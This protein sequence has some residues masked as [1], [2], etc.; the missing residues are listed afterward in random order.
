MTSQ[1][2]DSGYGFLFPEDFTADQRATAFI[3]W[4]LLARV[5]TIKLAQVSAFHPG[6]GTPPTAGTVDVQ[7]LVNM[8]DG[9][10]PPNATKRGIVYGLPCWRPRFGPWEIIGDPA[11]G[12]V[13]VVLCCDRDISSVVANK[14]QANPGSQRRFSVSD[15]LFLSFGSALN[16][17]ATATMWLKSDGTLNLTDAKGNSIVSAVGGM[18]LSDDNGNQIQM[19]AGKVNVV[20]ASFQVNGVPVT[21]P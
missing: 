10:T 7:L 16:A 11:V 5:D 21:V 3:F 4:Q 14:A 15:G 19:A 13:G 8:I 17:A 2:T 6:S 20:T 18:T 9:A 12:D 1:G